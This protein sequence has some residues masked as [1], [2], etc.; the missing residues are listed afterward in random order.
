MFLFYCFHIFGFGFQIL[1]FGLVILFFGFGFWLSVRNGF[2]YFVF[3]F[4]FYIFYFILATPLFIRSPLFLFGP[5]FFIWHPLFIQSLKTNLF[6]FVIHSL[7]LPLLLLLLLLLLQVVLVLGFRSIVVCSYLQNVLEIIKM[8]KTHYKCHYTTMNYYNIVLNTHLFLC[9]LLS[10][11][12]VISLKKNNY[13]LSTSHLVYPFQKKCCVVLCCVV[14][15]CICLLCDNTCNYQKK[16]KIQCQR[17]GL[18]CNSD[19]KTDELCH[20]RRNVGKKLV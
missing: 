5:L 20:H 14:D 11:P 2:L 4:V 18:T 3:G 15:I 9:S 6:L 13:F 17:C 1:F 8:C 10:V 7:L 16:E 19:N 12:P